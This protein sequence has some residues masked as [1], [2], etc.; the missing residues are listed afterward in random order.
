MLEGGAAPVLEYLATLRITDVD[1]FYATFDT[2][3]RLQNSEYLKPPTVKPLPVG[4]RAKGLF[5]LRL[6]GSRHSQ[7]V[8]I[9]LIYPPGAKREVVLLNG[10]TKKTNK[11][12]DQFINKAIS[13]R[14]KVLSKE[15]KYEQIPIEEIKRSLEF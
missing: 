1:R 4:K 9:A 3:E 8:R 5:E 13:L 2:M 6:Q 14:A 10:I 12:S 7:D 15:L 11:A